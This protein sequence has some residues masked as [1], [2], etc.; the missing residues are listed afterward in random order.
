MDA[1]IERGS[2]GGAL[3]DSQARLVGLLVDDVDRGGKFTYALPIA[4]V[5]TLR[6]DPKAV[7][8][9]A[10]VVPGAATA[11]QEGVAA[12]KKERHADAAKLFAQAL[13]Q[14]PKLHR[15]RHRLARALAATGDAEGATRELRA[16]LEAK[17]D[18][19]DAV[20]ELGENER[21]RGNL[22]AAFELFQR[23]AKTEKRSSRAAYV[24][25]ANTWRKRLT[26]SY[27]RRAVVMQTTGDNER[28]KMIQQR[29][30]GRTKLDLVL[31]S[32]VETA[33]LPEDKGEECRNTP[34]C[35]WRPAWARWVIASAAV[36][37][38]EGVAL[39]L[40][41][42]DVR[43]QKKLAEV[44]VR[45]S[46][47][48]QL[49]LDIDDQLVTLL[50][51]LPEALFKDGVLV[52]SGSGEDEE[53]GEAPRR[54]LLL[55]DDADP[56]GEGDG[57]EAAAS[58]APDQRKASARI[59][60]KEEPEE[61]RRIAVAEEQAASRINFV[62]FLLIGT[63]VAIAGTGV[64]VDLASPWSGDYRIDVFDFVGPGIIAAGVVT[65]VAGFFFFGGDDE[66]G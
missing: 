39:D 10:G 20:Y 2:R 50:A 31:S 57:D 11:Y 42:Y 38:D 45:S 35:V 3:L 53:G 58:G 66:E 23:Y 6:D 18:D 26:Q 5:V 41:L 21:V 33:F 54:R 52:A 24:K 15:A 56:P 59:L 8:P 19:L 12:Q 46:G 61:T 7:D 4:A 51:D 32:D 60:R 9:L 63:G 17:P 14:D 22:G 62:P 16:Y 36:D 43:Q 27:E 37:A 44:E 13:E 25:H 40:S 48:N 49:P 64:V 29:L 28:T 65:A 1:H 34:T 55:E 30:K 47:E